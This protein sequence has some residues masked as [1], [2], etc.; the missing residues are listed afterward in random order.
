MLTNFLTS[1]GMA[2][3]TK[4]KEPFYCYT[5]L[6]YTHLSAEKLWSWPLQKTAVKV[7]EDPDK[8]K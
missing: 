5:K 7:R 8:T 6:Q 2:L 1:S 4:Q 3:K